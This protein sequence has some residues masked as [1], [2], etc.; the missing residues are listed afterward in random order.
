MT[1][2]HH[3][4]NDCDT[5]T[6]VGLILKP[7]FIRVHLIIPKY[8]HNFR[9]FI[10]YM[11]L[12]NKTNLGVYVTGFK[13]IVNFSAD[14]VIFSSRRVNNRNL[15]CFLDKCHCS[16]YCLSLLQCN[17]SLSLST[18]LLCMIKC[19]S[20]VNIYFLNRVKIRSINHSFVLPDL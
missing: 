5:D 6:T 13:P 18:S 12:Y 16:S 2:P 8:G 7:F 20:I 14:G 15:A 11:Q 3:K 10:I 9:W 4:G 1:L 19:C 17:S